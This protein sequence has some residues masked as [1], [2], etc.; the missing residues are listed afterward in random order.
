MEVFIGEGDVLE[1]LGLGRRV[2]SDGGE[3]VVHW[4]DSVQRLKGIPTGG[5]HL[6]VGEGAGG[7]PFGRGWNGPRPKAG[8]GRFVSPSAF[9]IFFVSFL[10][11]FLFSLFYFYLLQKC[12]KSSQTTFRNFLKFLA[13]F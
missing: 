6:S 11:L 3:D 9:F 2:S 10:F 5:V 8:L 12:F 4:L 7:Y 1:G 13:L